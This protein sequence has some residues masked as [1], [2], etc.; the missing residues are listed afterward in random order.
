[1][2]EKINLEKFIP[3]RLAR[4]ATLISRDLQETYSKHSHLT[5]PEWRVLVTLGDFEKM[6][7][8]EG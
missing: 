3:Y 2:S 6:T 7:A 1:M 8:K 4:I 5:V